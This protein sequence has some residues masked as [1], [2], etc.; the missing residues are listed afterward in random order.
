LPQV[1]L[2]VLGG[3]LHNGTTRVIHH[4][5]HVDVNV[6]QPTPRKIMIQKLGLAPAFDEIVEIVPEGIILGC[7]LQLTQIRPQ[8]LTDALNSMARLVGLDACEAMDENS[9][10]AVEDSRYEH[11]SGKASSPE[12]WLAQ[13][14]YDPRVRKPAYPLIFFFG[15]LAAER[16]RG[17]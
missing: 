2:R 9:A 6:F 5:N 15:R 14:T 3:Q 12:N 16:T 1:T 17:A 11:Y 7:H 4:P 10:G 13:R 8:G